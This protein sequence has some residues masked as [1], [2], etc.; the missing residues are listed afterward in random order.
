MTSATFV[1]RPA[2][3]AKWATKGVKQ[4]P[5]THRLGQMFAI[6]TSVRNMNTCSNLNN[7]RSGGALR[8]RLES[9]VLKS[10]E[11]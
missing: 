3:R 4:A 2:L 7:T 9:E 10:K 6:R 1:A 5:A 8:R 11:L